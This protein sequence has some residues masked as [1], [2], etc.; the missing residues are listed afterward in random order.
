LVRRFDHF[1]SAMVLFFF[2]GLLCAGI[3]Y[4][5]ADFL[6][7]FVIRMDGVQGTLRALSPAVLFV[8]LYSVLWIF[9]CAVGLI[10]LA[11][12]I[13]RF[14]YPNAP[15][16]WELLQISA[17]GMPFAALNQTVAGGLQWC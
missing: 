13:Y 8:C 14:L 16:G 9:P 3:L 4:L 5:G 1:R 10:V 15:L 6:A 11:Q 12:P 2:I 7:R 17:L